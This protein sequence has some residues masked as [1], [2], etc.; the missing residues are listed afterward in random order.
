MCCLFGKKTYGYNAWMKTCATIIER[1]T[2]SL[3][4]LQFMCSSVG[5]FY[6]KNHIVIRCCLERLSVLSP[7]G[8]KIMYN[9]FAP[10]AKPGTKIALSW[11]GARLQVWKEIIRAFLCCQLSRIA[12]LSSFKICF[13]CAWIRCCIYGEKTCVVANMEEKKRLLRLSLGR[14]ES[15]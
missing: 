8:K 6:G 7:F 12:C 14:A 11:F 9:N 5:V 2:V 10:H 15:S 1:R 3:V 13:L 4:L